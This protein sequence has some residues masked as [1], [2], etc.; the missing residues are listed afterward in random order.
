MN[1][2]LESIDDFWVLVSNHFCIPRIRTFRTKFFFFITKKVTA[3]ARRSKLVFRRD[4]WRR[5][6]EKTHA[7]HEKKK[8]EPQTKPEFC[9]LGARIRA[10]T[11]TCHSPKLR[12]EVDEKSYGFDLKKN[13]RMSM[14]CTLG[15]MCCTLGTTTKFRSYY[16]CQFHH[17]SNA[18]VRHRKTSRSCWTDYRVF[19]QLTSSYRG[20]LR[21]ILH[22]S[23]IKTLGNQRIAPKSKPRNG[24][25]LSFDL[26]EEVQSLSFSY[27]EFHQLT[28]Q[29]A[30]WAGKSRFSERFWSSKSH[31]CSL[32]NLC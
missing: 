32:W 8:F 29:N 28:M 22:H 5:T 26:I 13:I 19:Q 24:S 21:L 1:Y 20:S 12:G 16:I 6:N 31:K 9:S 30:L 17:F 14:C 3:I 15:K 10:E 2:F 23:E 7:F 4:I 27:L 11:Q 25:H 18:F